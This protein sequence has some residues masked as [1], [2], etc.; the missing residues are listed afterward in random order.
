MAANLEAVHS[1]PPAGNGLWHELPI[2]GTPIATPQS[3]L[4]T[5]ESLVAGNSVVVVPSFVS[6][7]ECAALTDEALQAVL[8]ASLIPR[9]VRLPLMVGLQTRMAEEC[10]AGHRHEQDWSMEERPDQSR[11]ETTLAVLTAEADVI[12]E[13]IFR[14]VLGFVDEQFPSL[15]QDSFGAGKGASASLLEMYAA[16]ELEFATHEPAVN[17]YGAGGEFEPHKDYQGLTM[18]VAL[19]APDTFS[20]GGTGFWSH[21]ASAD[22]LEES[23]LLLK[24]PRGSVILFGGQVMHAG[25]A[26]EAGSRLVFVGSFSHKWFKPPGGFGQIFGDDINGFFY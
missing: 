14:R 11:S 20:G 21:E 26:V 2:A 17:V 1:Q 16:D 8:R 22:E 13:K 5:V 6:D 24:P 15:V 10:R 7:A 23:T 12:G 4:Q 25:I 18:L 9:C 19:S 3:T